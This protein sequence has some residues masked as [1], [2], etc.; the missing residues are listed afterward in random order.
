MVR[1]TLLK[2][3]LIFYHDVEKWP[4]KTLELVKRSCAVIPDFITE[5]EE[6][7]LLNEVFPHLKRMKYEET[8]WD[9]VSLFFSLEVIFRPYTYIENENRKSGY[10]RTRKFF[11]ELLQLHSRRMRCIYPTYIS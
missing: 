7:S 2:R 11:E 8:H 10:L 1:L 6:K 5:D 4:V 9:D 3:S